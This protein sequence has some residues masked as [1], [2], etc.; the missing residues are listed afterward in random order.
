[1]TLAILR[2]RRLSLLLLGCLAVGTAWAKP[3][4]TVLDLNKFATD[5]AIVLP[6]SFETDTHKMLEN[7]YLQNYTAL[8]ADVAS[9]PDPSVTD[10]EIIRLMIKDLA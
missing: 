6:E 7:W 3:R 1:M 10:E 2:P 4:A 9:R 5:S 8:D